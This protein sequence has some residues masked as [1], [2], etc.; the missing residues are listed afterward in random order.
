MKKDPTSGLPEDVKVMYNSENGWR[1]KSFLETLTK[2]GDELENM[3]Q[4]M[5][6]FDI[7][8]DRLQRVEVSKIMIPEM[9]M[10]G[11]IS[12][13]F[14]CYGLYKYANMCLRSQLET[15]LRLIYFATHR[16]E[17]N[18]WSNGNKWYRSGM[19]KR[20]VWGDGYKYFE[21]LESIKKFDQKCTSERK[22]FTGGGV[23][24]RIY[25]TLSD[26]VHSGKPSFQIRSNEFSPK[27]KIDQFKKWS[28]N[29]K[30][31]QEC[32]QVLLALGFI[33]EFRGL[34]RTEKERILKTSIKTDY[35]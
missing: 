7:W 25:S 28:S 8:S 1:S 35:Q 32:T 22:L 6:I 3:I 21:E 30:A 12:I 29:F 17:F 9:F 26:Y 16:V 33:N 2:H 15:N 13:H 18:W 20:D 27:Y 5:N 24:G 31:V 11:Y 23:V 10:D 19:G 14:S 34:R 4:T